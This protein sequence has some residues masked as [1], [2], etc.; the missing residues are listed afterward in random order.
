MAKKRTSP[1]KEKPKQPRNNPKRKDSSTSASTKKNHLDYSR[2]VTAIEQV[3]RSTQRHAAQSVNILLSIRSW[4]VGHNIVEYEQNGADRANYGK[5]LLCLLATE[6]KRKNL[7]GFSVTNLRLYR[8]FYR[9]YPQFENLLLCKNSQEGRSFLPEAIRGS[10]AT[11]FNMPENFPIHQSVT[12]EFK[13]PSNERN[14]IESDTVE[15]RKMDAHSCSPKPELLLQHFTFTHFVEL[16]KIDDPIKR[17]FYE[18]EGIKGNWSVRQL[19]RQMESLLFERTGLSKNKAAL[20]NRVHRQNDVLKVEDAIRDPYVWEFAGLQERPEYS[21]K[22]LETAL[23]DH[24]QE[25][26]LELGNGFCFEARQKRITIDDEH[27]RVDLV[28]YHRILK[29]HILVDLKIRKFSYADAGQM[30]FYLN[31]FKENVMTT[32]DNPPIGLI[33]CSDKTATKVK[34]S[35]SGMDN[36]MFVS[37]YLISLPSERELEEF[38]A[39][40]REFIESQVKQ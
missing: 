23:L 10:L 29:C 36:Q 35:I 24:L 30:N 11:K 21:E 12:D 8:L 13:D 1:K 27:D 14:G 18:I 40:D 34:Y 32:G 4:L 9:T 20:L 31:Y 25:F 7:K 17:A 28:F 22:E 6:L 26:L 15:Q 3:H 19:K 39:K 38:I 16:L 2:L 33:L 37:K 5:N